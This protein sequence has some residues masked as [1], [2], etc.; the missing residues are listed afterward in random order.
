[1]CFNLASTHLWA[2]QMTKVKKD[3]DDGFYIGM[4]KFKV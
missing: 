4:L 3:L 2:E 1:M